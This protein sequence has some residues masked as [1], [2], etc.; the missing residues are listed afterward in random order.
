MSSDKIMESIRQVGN[1]QAGTDDEAVWQDY[2]QYFTS[3]PA[4]N[5]KQVMTFVDTECLDTIP[6]VTK[7]AAKMLQKKRQL[8]GI[9]E[10]MLKAGR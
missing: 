1:Y 7:S 3:L 5:R 9:N 4:L 10:L 6:A 2:I 8:E